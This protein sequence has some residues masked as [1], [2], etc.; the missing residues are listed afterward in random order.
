MRIFLLILI[1][2]INISLQI[3]MPNF[4]NFSVLPN[5]SIVLVVCYS[6]LRSDVEGAT[7]G[8]FVGLLQD[9]IFSSYLGYFAAI[10]LFIGYVSNHILKHVLN[11]NVIP[12]FF[13][14]II[15]TF[16]YNIQIYFISYFFRGN[17]SLLTYLYKIVL[18]EAIMNAI[19]TIPI[20]YMLYFLDTKLRK[21][22]LKPAKYYTSLKPKTRL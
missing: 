14:T 9:M 6:Y 2:I 16:L 1:A 21:H 12:V 20:F 4:F 15:S 8:F 19:L 11:L 5:T 17:F 13:I 3:S 7:Y 10:Y 18:P 22:E